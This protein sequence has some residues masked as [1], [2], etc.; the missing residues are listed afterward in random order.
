MKIAFFVSGFPAFSETFIVNQITGLI[1][2]GHDVQ[3]YA[4]EIRTEAELHA[5][6]HKYHLLERTRLRRSVTSRSRL[7]K[8]SARLSLALKNVWRHPSVVFRALNVF[9]YGR[10][11]VSLYVLDMA[12]RFVDRP[13]YDIVHCHFGTNGNDAA[14]L[15]E[16]GL[17]K[18]RLVTTFHGYDIRQGMAS[19]GK[20]YARLTRYCDAVHSISEYNRRWLEAFGFDPARIIHHP[21]GI[22]IT[23]FQPRTGQYNRQGNDEPVTIVTVARLVQEKGIGY[24]LEA[25]ADVRKQRPNL[26][27]RYRILGGGLLENSLRAQ[28]RQLG[29]D[30]IVELMGPQNQTVV[31]S[32]LARADL[33]LLPSVAEA[34]PVSIMEAM[35]CGLPVV[36]TE[37]GSVAELVKDGHTGRLV[38]SADAKALA[39]A[40]LEMLEGRENWSKLGSA[41]RTLVAQRYDIEML[42]DRLVEH[43]RWLL[44]HES[45]S[46]VGA[47]CSID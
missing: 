35:A 41:G 11:A 15:M 17:L 20:I 18:G 9:A 36:A 40:L 44:N 34:L 30:D 3:I 19:A 23:R 37:V 27:I 38:P 47:V 1:D 39:R 6:C 5:E 25:L 22:D 24:A 32:V 14:I 2:R 28:A 33:F 26:P 4:S 31:R 45:I 16:L 43:Y 7:L 13:S 42:N 46:T 10:R 29:L 8:L 12:L 21:I